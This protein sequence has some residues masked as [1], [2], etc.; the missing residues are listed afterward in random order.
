MKIQQADFLKTVP[1]Y[2]FFKT[3][4]TTLKK[5]LPSEF[6]SRIQLF[7]YLYFQAGID[8][9]RAADRSCQARHTPGQ[10]RDNPRPGHSQTPAGHPQHLQGLN[11]YILEEMRF[12]WATASARVKEYIFLKKCCRKFYFHVEQ[13]FF[14]CKTVILGTGSIE[15]CEIFP[16]EFSMLPCTVPQHRRKIRLIES[17]AKC[18]YLKKLTCKRT[19]RQVFYLSEASL[20][21]NDPILS[22]P[23]YT[24]YTYI[25]YTYSHREG[26]GG[27]NHG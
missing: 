11:S 12:S 18:R 5:I 20:S 15:K 3:E 25:L 27:A 4:Q 22:P 7:L 19:L 6:T 10:C 8:R 1:V 23:P 24:L 2:F 17:N 14:I 9:R 21:S 26:G 16:M 13:K